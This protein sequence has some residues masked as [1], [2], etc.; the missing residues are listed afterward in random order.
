MRGLSSLAGIAT[1]DIPL[2]YIIYVQL[3]VF[4]LEQFQGLF[5][6]QVAG[7][8]Q[9]IYVFEELQLK[10]V[11]VRYNQTVPV[12]Q[13][14]SASFIFTQRDLFKVSNTVL[15]QL[16]RFLDKFVIQVF[17]NYNLFNRLIY[18]FKDVYRKVSSRR[19]KYFGTKQGLISVRARFFQ[20]QRVL[21][22]L[23]QGIRLLTLN[24]QAV[25]N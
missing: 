24:A 5:L 13:A 22:V 14:V 1:R 2:Y 18:Y 8:Q 21:R 6:A 9:I 4:L 20:Y 15:N 10:F 16:K 12:V 23:G 17:V 19:V 25:R 3:V 11:V 7:Y